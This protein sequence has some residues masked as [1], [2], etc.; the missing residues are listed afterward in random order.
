MRTERV[1]TLAGELYDPMAAE[2]AAGRERARDLCQ[3]LNAMREAEQNE[4]RRIV[5]DLFWSGG[6]T[7]LVQVW[8]GGGAIIFAECGSGRGPSSARGA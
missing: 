5:S 7:V 3:A 2:L 6:D 4:R 1:K 8:V